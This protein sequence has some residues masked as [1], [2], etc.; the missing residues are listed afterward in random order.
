[1]EKVEVTR[2]ENLTDLR[3]N[4]VFGFDRLEINGTYALK[5]WVGWTELDS[6]GEKDFSIKMVN[7]TVGLE[8]HMDLLK[9]E[10]YEHRR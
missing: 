10:E 5:G 7:A 4:V 9:P 1:M 3:I 2:S 6:H 8:L